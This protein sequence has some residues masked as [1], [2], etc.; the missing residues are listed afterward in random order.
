M[1]NV[2]FSWYMIYDLK[3]TEIR[4]MTKYT[5]LTDSANMDM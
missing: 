2:L 1:I 4:E 5:R 3:T